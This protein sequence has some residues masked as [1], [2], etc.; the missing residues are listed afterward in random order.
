MEP[1]LRSASVGEHLSQTHVNSEV[2]CA[3]LSQLYVFKECGWVAGCGERS[4]PE[5]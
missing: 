1:Q 4:L 5:L 3:T 2:W